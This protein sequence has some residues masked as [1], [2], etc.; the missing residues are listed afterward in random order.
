[1]KKIKRPSAKIFAAILVGFACLQVID[2]NAVEAFPGQEEVSKGLS[3]AR[4]SQREVVPLPTGFWKVEWKGDFSSCS[5]NTFLCFGASGRAMILKNNDESG[6]VKALIIRHSEGESWGAATCYKAVG[7]ELSDSHGTNIASEEI[8]CSYGLTLLRPLPE[9][10]EWYW[11]SIKSGLEVLNLE[12]K[13]FFVIK[14]VL[15]GPRSRFFNIDIVIDR[16]RDGPFII[17]NLQLTSWKRLYVEALANGLFKGASLPDSSI[18]D[19]IQPSQLKN[20]ASQDDS[21]SVSNP[22]Y[23]TEQQEVSASKKRKESDATGEMLVGAREE[24]QRKLAEIQRQE[25]ELKE[26]ERLAQEAIERERVAKAEAEAQQRRS[27]ELKRQEEERKEAERLAREKV[28]REKVAQAEAEEQQR[29]LAEL[30]KKE[31][32]RKEIERLAQEAAERE[33]VA[34][35]EAKEQQRKL[36]ELRR[37]EEERKEAERRE[38]LRLAQEAAE[39]EKVVKA[40]AKKRLQIA[41]AARQVEFM[42]AQLKRFEDNLAKIRAQQSKLEVD[43]ANISI[44]SR[45]PRH[46]LVVGNAQYTSV[47]GLGNS[48]ADAKAFA[49]AL[50]GFGFQ[51]ALHTDIKDAEFK[52]AVLDFKTRLETGAEVVFYFAG[53]GVQFGTANYLLPVDV[54]AESSDGVRQS[55]VELQQILNSISE[56]KLRFTLAVIDACRDNPFTVA[57]ASPNGRGLKDNPKMTAILNSKGIT[58][59]N[60]AAVGQMVIYSASAGQQAL[61]NLGPNDPNPN[62]LFTRIFLEKMSQPGIPVD[63]VLRQVKKEVVR[64]AKSVSHEQVPALYDQTVGEFFFKLEE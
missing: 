6:V 49:K 4:I 16:Y 62:G 1:M 8:K 60:T 9:R 22:A 54:G 11:S 32:E 59:T 21:S 10:D 23:A 2:T 35:A 40:E 56:K 51:V 58:P 53:H 42:Q 27:A 43:Q 7:L 19:L 44:P 17:E 5:P 33:R 41:E 55:S 52:K 45:A 34:K 57:A 37:Q 28:E 15:K 29:S 48:V 3:E 36:A 64:L 63:S 39:R 14:V 46:A 24:Q 61:D 50:D 30:K 18:L 38:A 20:V 31:D 47:G 26:A 25:E 13:P 12:R